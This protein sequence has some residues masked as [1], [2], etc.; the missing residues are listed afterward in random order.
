MPKV[1]KFPRLRNHVRKGKAG[2]VNTYYFYDMRPEGKPDVPLGK[3]YAEAIRKWRELHERAPRI[4]GRLQEA[5]DRWR[6]EEL[7]GYAK[8][9]TRRSYAK[10]LAKVEAVFGEMLWEDVTLPLMHEYLRRRKAKVQG[11]REMSVLSVVWGKAR[12]WGMTKLP[13]PA[14][15]VKNW[16]N[17]ETARVFDVTDALFD[18]VYAEGS[19]ML[20]DAMD[21]A[22]ATG[23]RLTDVRTILLPADNVLH[24]KAN[25]TSKGADFDLSLSQVLPDLIARRRAVKVDHLMLLSAGGRPVTEKRLQAHYDRAR[26]RAAVKAY[27]GNDDEFARL[28][29]AMYLR[30]MRKRAADL[31]GDLE[32]ASKLLQHSSLKLTENHYRPRAAQLKPV[33]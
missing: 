12:L 21:I 11:N 4:V 15:G 23:M 33:R 24:L 19:Q 22:T 31:A 32:Q 13:W 1:T 27:I 2:Q 20:R 16:K 9:E 14:A 3:D 30:D 26:E 8:V 7:P 28:L 5:F 6:E 10:Q 18:A 25:K 17:E 29:K